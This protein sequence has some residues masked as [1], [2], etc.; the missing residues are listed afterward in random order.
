MSALVE[1]IAAR[2][3]IARDRIAR[4]GGDPSLVRIVAVTKGFGP[5]VLSA[6]FAAGFSDFGENYASELVEKWATVARAARWH[7]LGAVQR[8]KI[9]RLAPY[10][11]CWQCVARVLEGEAIMRHRAEDARAGLESASMLV[12]VET[13]GIAGRGGCRPDEVKAVVEGLLEHGCR[14]E[15]LMTVAPPGDPERARAAFERVARLRDELGLK[16][17]SMGMSEDLEQAVAAGATMVRLG[18]SLFGPR[19]QRRRL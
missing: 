8:N 14:V 2:A 19:P 18:T 1:E 5:E 9:G 15:G 7:F 10:V 12:E 13:T 4:A 17:L 6:A 3:E 16:E 11:D